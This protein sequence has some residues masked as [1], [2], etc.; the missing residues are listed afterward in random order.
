MSSQ[1]QQ[2]YAFP[3]RT[4]VFT[5]IIVILAGIFGGWLINR[6][7]T[8]PA[9]FQNRGAANPADFAEEQR[10]KMT[11]EGRDAALSELRQNERTLATS[12]GWADQP[13]GVV[14]LP[15]DRAIELTVR[16]Y[17]R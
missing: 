6:A 7:Y 4:P 10:W 15:I 13:A 14:R 1:P 9:P 17:A 12:Y 3:Q 2:P 11:P 16:T 8:P 5:A